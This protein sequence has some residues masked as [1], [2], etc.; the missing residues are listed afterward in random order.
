MWLCY[1]LLIRGVDG[2]RP[3]WLQWAL[4]VYLYEAHAEDLLLLGMSG[5][6]LYAL[7]LNMDHERLQHGSFRRIW[8]WGLAFTIVGGLF[9]LIHL[10]S[11]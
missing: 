4:Y 9:A 10:A 3:F 2:T 8:G 1:V 7:V 6:A 11:D 5:L